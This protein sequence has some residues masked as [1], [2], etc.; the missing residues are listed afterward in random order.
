MLKLSVPKLT[1]AQLVVMSFV[2]VI[3]I[4]TILLRLPY[5]HVGELSWT[6]AVFTATSATC[7]TG[8]I[9]KDTGHDFTMFGQIV[10]MCLIQIGG[11]GLMTLSSA[12]LLLMGRRLTR[13][14][15]TIVRDMF[16]VNGQIRLRTLIQGILLVTLICEALGSFILYEWWQSA[17]PAHIPLMMKENL[18]FSAI[19][20]AIS[21]FCNAGFSLFSNNLESFVRD[22][23]TTVVIALLFIIGG[24]GYFVLVELI[25]KIWK[26]R[27]HWRR[28]PAVLSLHTRLVLRVTFILILSG[29]ILIL[30]FESG[31]PIFHSLNWYQRLLAAF[32]QAVTPRTA[33]FNTL[34]ID[35]LTTPT[36]LLMMTLMV[37]GASP[38]STGGGIKT[39]TLAIL[40]GSAR[41]EIQGDDEV[42]I[43]HRRI[44][45][46]TV[47]R[48]IAVGFIALGV[49]GVGALFILFFEATFVPFK[50]VGG[51]Y[52][53]ILF[54]TISA[55]GTV[56]LSTGLTGQLTTLSKWLLS[57]IMLFGRVGPLTIVYTITERRIQPQT[58]ELPEEPVMIG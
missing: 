55:F 16:D 22:P 57:I 11:L 52:L 41:A 46:E 51:L 7:V 23:V 53:R 36:L 25:W 17:P 20:H 8:L 1:T 28:L 35:Q 58:I 37:I 4:G 15:W 12:F 34:P 54:E 31:N 56:G 24:L 9:V 29:T 6:D 38:G 44:P 21:A 27:H 48:A 50:H 42:L 3:F 14:H 40:Y 43:M 2:L 49:I 47:R 19:F 32:F 39:T 45:R 30:V 26:E 33:G 13:S 5:A 18:L 10:I